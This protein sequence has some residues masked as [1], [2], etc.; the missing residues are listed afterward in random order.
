L[1]GVGGVSPPSRS[2][3]CPPLPVVKVGSSIANTDASSATN[4][5]YNV[6]VAFF[7]VKS[8]VA[9]TQNSSACLNVYETASLQV[10]PSALK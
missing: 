8:A 1:V 10:I 2:T 7:N 4:L 5:I 6:D 3:I 9:N